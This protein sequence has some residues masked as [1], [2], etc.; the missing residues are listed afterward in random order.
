MV[1][2]KDCW[3]NW[4]RINENSLYEIRTHVS[5]YCVQM[6]VSPSPQGL[7]NDVLCKVKFL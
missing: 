3:M 4:W 5:G 1:D 6:T 7:C 2:E